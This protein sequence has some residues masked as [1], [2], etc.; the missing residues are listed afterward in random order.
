MV[1]CI[2]NAYS[3]SRPFIFRLQK[4]ISFFLPIVFR[5]LLVTNAV[6]HCGDVVLHCRYGH[7]LDVYSDTFGSSV[8]LET[9][10]TVQ[11]LDI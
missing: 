5:L 7:M 10:Q 9:Q 8:V 2:K 4:R 6:I 3:Q 11:V 1:K